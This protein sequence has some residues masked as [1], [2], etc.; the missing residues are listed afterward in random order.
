MKLLITRQELLERTPID[1]STD[2]DKIVPHILTAQDT[3]VQNVLGTKLYDKLVK[4][5]EDGTLT[6]NYFTLLNKYVKPMLCHYAAADFYLFHHFTI[7]NGGVF[8]HNSE[9]SSTSTLGE[10]EVLCSAQKANAVHYRTSLVGYICNDTSRFPEYYA[11]QQGQMY[12]D[13]GTPSNQI[14]I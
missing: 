11:D 12:P 14:V 8:S 6:G 13:R 1:G 5:N 4:D 2:M 9:N 7:A 3:H 10:I